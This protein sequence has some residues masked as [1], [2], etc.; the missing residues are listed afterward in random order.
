[1]GLLYLY[2]RDCSTHQQTCDNLRRALY[3]SDIDGLFFNSRP[4]ST[5]LFEDLTFLYL[6]YAPDF[7]IVAQFIF[8]FTSAE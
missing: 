2:P 7:S 8:V 3:L 4:Y 5:A 6:F 1:M